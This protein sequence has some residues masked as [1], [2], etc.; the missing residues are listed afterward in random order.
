MKL[1]L[2]LDKTSGVLFTPWLLLR[3]KIFRWIQTR[4]RSNTTNFTK[5]LAI[6]GLAFFFL[7]SLS[8]NET[9]AKMTVH[10]YLYVTHIELTSSNFFFNPLALEDFHTFFIIR[11]E[12]LLWVLVR[13]AE[14]LPNL[15][16]FISCVHVCTG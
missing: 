14:L 3:R 10:V 4:T 15:P 6:S 13:K 5:H 8:N 2:N 12:Y 16:L 11:F 9:T 7:L 1:I